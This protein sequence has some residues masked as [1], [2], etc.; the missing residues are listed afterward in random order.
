[1]KGQMSLPWYF[2]FELVMLGVVAVALMIYVRGEVNDTTYWRNYFARDTAL[3]MD[4][5]PV[6]DGDVAFTYQQ[7]PQVDLK[8]GIF[9]E[10]GTDRVSVYEQSDKKKNSPANFPYATDNRLT[11][12][13]PET[14]VPYIIYLNKNGNRIEVSQQLSLSG[15]IDFSTSANISEKRIAFDADES[16]QSHLLAQFRFDLPLEHLG[17]AWDTADVRIALFQNSS[18]TATKLYY[19]DGPNVFGMQ[20][21]TCILK[22]RYDL[23]VTSILSMQELPVRGVQDINAEIAIVILTP[24]L[25]NTGQEQLT[26]AI[27]ETLM[28][29]YT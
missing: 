14:F 28:E 1:M 15:C 16:M 17:V 24:P 6:A 5:L 22:K 2:I 21:F 29:Y 23:D 9:I 26:T 7:I 4:L 3:I 8:Q 12:L 19:L 10:F 13:L 18:Y 27:K 11:Y 20:K 25:D